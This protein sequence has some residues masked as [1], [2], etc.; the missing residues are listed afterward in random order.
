MANPARHKKPV[1]ISCGLHAVQAALVRYVELLD[2]TDQPAHTFE[3][4][5]DQTRHSARLQEIIDLAAAHHIN[6][7]RCRR[8][9]LDELTLNARHQG[10]AARSGVYRYRQPEQL[11]QLVLQ[12]ESPP[13]LLLLDRIQDPH[14]LGACLRSAEGAGV[15]AVI[16][17]K[18]GCCQVNQTVSKVAA[19]AAERV[20]VVQIVNLVQCIQKLQQL[21]VWITGASEAAEK[22]IYQLDL[23]VATG[24]VI[25][26][27]GRGLRPRTQQHC[28]QLGSIPMQGRLSS[29]NAS[30][31]TGVILFEALRQRQAAGRIIG[32][33]VQSG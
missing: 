21:G 23:T 13:L 28:D 3:L 9:T 32:A 15:S 12:A 33:G 22:T 27:E 1:A 7:I 19:G 20:P 6:L 17:P 8:Q 18:D 29:L 25:G 10:V 4:Y 26:A 31:A 11:W 5:V 2:S 16:L 24:I 14:N 30:V